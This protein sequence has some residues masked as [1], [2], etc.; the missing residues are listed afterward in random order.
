MNCIQSSKTA[1]GCAQS[2]GLLNKHCLI[3]GVIPK[4]QVATQRREG[5]DSIE[6]RT[7][8]LA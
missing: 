8:P 3:F 2:H 4:W 7:S 1:R 5:N 6:C